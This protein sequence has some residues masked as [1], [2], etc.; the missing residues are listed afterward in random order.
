MAES[1]AREQ[2]GNADEANLGDQDRDVKI[3]G[4]SSS[5]ADK[6]VETP[7]AEQESEDEE[8]HGNDQETLQGMQ[9]P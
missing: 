1:K 3:A 6:Q 7:Q 4:V 2:K 9:F 5:G 8:V